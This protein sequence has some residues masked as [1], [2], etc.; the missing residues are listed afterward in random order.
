MIIFKG[1]GEARLIADST[2]MA[3]NIKT[4]HFLY[5]L[6]RFNA[7]PVRLCVPCCLR[8]LVDLNSLPGLL[9]L[10]IIFISE[11]SFRSISKLPNG[12]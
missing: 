10:E 9:L 2:S 6:T 11:S 3:T 1:Q 7:S 4:S 12:G 8:V 5:G